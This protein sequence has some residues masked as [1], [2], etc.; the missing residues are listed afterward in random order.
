[1]AGVVALHGADV[2]WRDGLWALGYPPTWAHTVGEAMRV[3]EA[4]KKRA[5]WVAG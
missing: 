5:E 3:D 1:M 4:C 2:V